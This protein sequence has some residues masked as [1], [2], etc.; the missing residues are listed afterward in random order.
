VIDLYDLAR[1]DGVEAARM[2]HPL[3]GASHYTEEGHRIIAGLLL[4]ALPQ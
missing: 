2:H 3:A 1:A 4:K